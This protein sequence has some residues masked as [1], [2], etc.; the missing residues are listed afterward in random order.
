MEKDGIS[1]KK[2]STKHGSVSQIVE[3][4]YREDEDE[5]HTDHEERGSHNPKMRDPRMEPGKVNYAESNR[6]SNKTNP[7]PGKVKFGTHPEN[8]EE[9]NGSFGRYDT[10][11]SEEQSNDRM[12]T[13][14][15]GLKETTFGRD[16]IAR[17]VE[18]H[19]PSREAAKNSE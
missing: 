10:G 8:P 13:G 2:K 16:E 9:R 11:K 19:Q 17:C 3:N 6:V 12:Q 5:M 15:V 1:R 18:Q 14:K 4:V 7:R